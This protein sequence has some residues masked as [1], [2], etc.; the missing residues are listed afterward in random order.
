M[1]EQMTV[2]TTGPTDLDRYYDALAYL[3][4]EITRPLSRL[5]MHGLNYAGSDGRTLCVTASPDAARWLGNLAPLVT[6][7]L[8]YAGFQR[9]L[10]NPSAAERAKLSL[11]VLEARE[12]AQEVAA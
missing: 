3:D 12:V 1:P 8:A 10:V 4:H 7:A 6:R 11:D 9:L 2:S 5:L